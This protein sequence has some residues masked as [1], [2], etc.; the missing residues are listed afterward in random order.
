MIWFELI[1]CLGG[2]LSAVEDS[3]DNN[4]LFLQLVVDGEREFA[5]K[6]S[7]VAFDLK[8]NAG[9]FGDRIDVFEDTVGKILSQFLS[10]L[11]S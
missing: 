1:R 6:G 2:S 10:A 9:R 11:N 7:V 3:P 4:L 8:M 5:R